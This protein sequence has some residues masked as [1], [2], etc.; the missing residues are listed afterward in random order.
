MLTFK[1]MLSVTTALVASGTLVSAQTTKP[2]VA[3]PQIASMSDGDL[4]IVE[5]IAGFPAGTSAITGANLANYIN[6][7]LNVAG[8]VSTNLT[9][10]Q[11]LLNGETVRATTAEATVA[12]AAAA[13]QT[14]ADAAF[15]ASSAGTAATQNVGPGG[16]APYTL[17]TALPA[18][19]GGSTTA[20]VP[21]GQAFQ[22]Q[23]L[24]L[25]A[26]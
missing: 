13:A 25:I 1:R 20:P 9:T 4:F 8:Q 11:N 19:T 17:I 14:T 22:C 21:T 15:P 2:I 3:L 16:V 24:V 26:Q 5:H 10:F 7:K 18:C 23:G 6:G 12:S